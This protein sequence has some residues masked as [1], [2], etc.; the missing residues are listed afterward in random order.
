MCVPQNCLSV[1]NL[2]SVPCLY[3]GCN[4][5]LVSSWQ[6]CTDSFNNFKL[7]AWQSCLGL[8]GSTSD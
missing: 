8:S 4:S 1:S 6:R 2:S 7:L 3:E 5:A